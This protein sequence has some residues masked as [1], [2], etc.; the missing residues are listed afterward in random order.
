MALHV[1]NAT[2]PNAAGPLTKPLIPESHAE[3]RDSQAV[4]RAHA[5]IRTLLVD[6]Q[7]VSLEILRH[8]LKREPDIEVV[9]TSANGREAVAAILQ[10]APD[11]VFLDVQMPELDG[12]GVVSE[13]GPARMPPFIFI[14]ANHESAAKAAQVHALDFLPKPCGRARLHSALERAREEIARKPAGDP[15]K[16]ERVAGGAKGHEDLMGL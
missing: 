9:G 4:V 10:V 12:F 11:L 15:P 13:V 1:V 5:K 3:S 7:R 8:M 6:D 16:R 14:T 2:V